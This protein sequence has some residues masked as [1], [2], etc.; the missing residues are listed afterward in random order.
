MCEQECSREEREPNALDSEGVTASDSG[1]EP[2][3]ASRNGSVLGLALRHTLA[4]CLLAGAC[5][6]PTSNE[7]GGGGEIACVSLE[8]VSVA[9]DEAVRAART[10]ALMVTSPPCSLDADC[11]LGGG[12]GSHSCVNGSRFGWCPS[13]AVHGDIEAQIETIYHEELEQICDVVGPGCVLSA[14][15][16]YHPAQTGVCIDSSCGLPGRW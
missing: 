12:F 2:R 13:I 16:V 3:A 1:W 11:V 9:Y 7:D 4:A 8:V 14:S 10:R 5:A 6:A 15:C